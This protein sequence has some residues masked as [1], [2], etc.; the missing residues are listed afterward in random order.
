MNLFDVPPQ[1]M[2]VV[3]VKTPDALIPNPAL[4]TTPHFYNKYAVFLICL[5]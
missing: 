5:K 4:G 1:K 2:W 3:G